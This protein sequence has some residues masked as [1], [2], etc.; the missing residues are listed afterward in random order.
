VVEQGKCQRVFS[1]P[2]QRY[3]RQLLSAD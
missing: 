1:A 2:T 3:T